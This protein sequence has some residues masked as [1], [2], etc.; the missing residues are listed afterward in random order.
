MAQTYFVLLTAAGEAKIANAAALGTTV[1]LTALAVGDGNGNTPTPDRL[2]TALVHE[3]RRAPINTLSIDPNNASQ[4]I[5]E[6]VIPEDVGGWWI[7]EIGLYDDAGV[8]CAVANC[9]PTYKPLLAEGSGRTQVVRM[10]LIVSSTQAV[11]LKI[12]P[13]I[14]LATRDYC[15]RSIDTAISKLDMKQ[16]VRAATKAAI[17]LNGLQTVDGVVLAAG[18]RVL[19]K[20]QAAGKDNGIYIAAAGAWTRAADADAALEVTPGML[21]PV[22]EGATNGDSVF[23]LVTDGAIV[24]GTTSLAFE[25]AAGRTGVTTGT[26][27]SVTVDARGR[28]TGGTNPQPTEAVAGP[29]IVATQAE[30]NTGTD[31]TKFVTAKKLSAWVKQATETVLGLAK[32]AT[33]AQTNAGTDDATIVTPK[34]LRAGFAINLSNIGY[35][36]FP[37]WLGG[38]IIQWGQYSTSGTS[39]PA[40][41]TYALAYPTGTFCLVCSSLSGLQMGTLDSP[42]SWSNTGFTV[43]GVQVNGSPNYSAHSGSYI[44]IGR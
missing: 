14:V 34:K 7:R 44:S 40:G 35:I 21:M 10:V 17:A 37:S 13:A 18:D 24:I 19:V 33:Q 42:Y 31:D 9:P 15:D 32:V 5:A 8:L 20:D 4:L 36:V 39:S 12:D 41:V 2:Q 30:V 29:A 26:Y 25:M 38:L 16:S 6:Q 11:T 43:I 1:N 22:E 27:S 28:V 3:V 23:Q